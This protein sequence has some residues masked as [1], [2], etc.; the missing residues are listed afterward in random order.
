MIVN[1]PLS[2][3]LLVSIG[4]GH[5]RG[6]SAL[7]CG[8]FSCQ[9]IICIFFVHY[10]MADYSKKAYASKKHLVCLAAKT[11][12]RVG[13]FRRRLTMALTIGRLHLKRRFAFTYGSFGLITMM[14]FFK[15]SKKRQRQ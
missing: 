6:M 13:D 12:F 14:S 5:V 8:M 3:Y 15:V 2:A 7:F 10:A 9:Q 11:Q 4:T 1:V